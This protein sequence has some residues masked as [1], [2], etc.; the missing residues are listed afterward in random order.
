MKNDW[1]NREFNLIL[2][3]LV[4][5]A[6]AAFVAVRFLRLNFMLGIVI[7]MIV[8]FLIFDRVSAQH[9]ALVKLYQASLNDSILVVQNVLTEKG[10]PYRKSGADRFLLERDGIE[11][12]LKHVQRR[13]G[14]DPCTVLKLIPHDTDSW[15]LIFSLRDKLDDAFRPRGMNL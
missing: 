1:Q 11:I 7:F 5:G 2:L 13:Y 15:H 10:I 3:A 4:V 6:G 14:G 8:F 9:K 12:S